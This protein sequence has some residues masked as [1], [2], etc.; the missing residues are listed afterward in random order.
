[1]AVRRLYNPLG[2][3]GTLNAKDLLQAVLLCLVVCLLKLVFTHG[4][5]L[6]LLL[7]HPHQLHV[8]LVALLADG[9]LCF[10]ASIN[11]IALHHFVATSLGIVRASHLVV[12]T[13]FHRPGSNFAA[14]HRSFRSH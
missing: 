8:K 11:K 6:G 12:K 14:A 4:L 10:R 3:L 1:M 2:G 5:G 7:E 9:R 13:F